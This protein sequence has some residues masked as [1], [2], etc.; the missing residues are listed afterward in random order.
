MPGIWGDGQRG[1]IF[2]AKVDPLLV[3]E[4]QRRAV[5]KRQMAQGLE[6]AAKAPSTIG[7]RAQDWWNNTTFFKPAYDELMGGLTAPGDVMSGAQ[8]TMAA[9]PQT[10]EF[11]TDPRLMDRAGALA[12]AVTL[13]AGAIPAEANSLRMGIKAYH[14]S[15]H[16]FERFDS[17]KIGTGEGAQVYGH[18][19]LGVGSGMSH[20]KSMLDAYELGKKVAAAREKAGVSQT[21]FFERWAYRG[22][23]DELTPA[24]FDAYSRLEMDPTLRAFMEMG[25]KGLPLPTEAT[26][27]RYGPAPSGG[28]SRNLRDDIDELGVSMAG[29]ENHPDWAGWEW[30]DSP[31]QGNRAK[32]RYEGYLLPEKGSD[33]EPLFVGVK[34]LSEARK[35][36]AK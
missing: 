8:P 33:D 6:S 18:G 7:S 19:D 24:S 16:S 15:P 27:W 4:L 26:G 28:A 13:G 31:R 10:G 9:D 34:A 3:A 29:V 1:G 5:E 12:G 30:F 20:P 23:D 32:H 14:G 36:L 2:G 25:R 21:E 22:I 17:S 11:H 35:K